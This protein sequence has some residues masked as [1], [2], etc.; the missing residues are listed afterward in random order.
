MSG[1]G[2]VLS[3]EPLLESVVSQSLRGSPRSTPSQGPMQDKQ[4]Q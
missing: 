4:S 1:D 3:N 2:K